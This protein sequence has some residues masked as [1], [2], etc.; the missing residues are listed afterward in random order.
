M[1][2]DSRQR[3]MAIIVASPLTQNIYERIGAEVIAATFNVVVIDCLKWIRNYSSEPEYVCVNA[4]NIYAINNKEDF[5]NVLTSL[6]PSFVLDFIGRCEY[7][8]QIQDIC[9][10]INA[11]YITHLLAPFPNPITKNKILQSLIKDTRVTISKVFYYIVRKF[12]HDRLLPPDVALLAGIESY[13]DWVGSAK[14]II[15]TATPAY[16]DLK[17]VQFLDKT[18]IDVPEDEYILFIDDCLALSF[19]FLLGDYK[20]I[21]SKEKYFPM[22]NSFFSKVEG[23]YKKPVVIAAHPN[24]KEYINYNNYFE[25]RKLYFDATAKLSLNCSFVLTHYS[26]AIAYPVL[27]RKPIMLMNFGELEVQSQGRSLNFMHE[28][29]SCEKVNIDDDLDLNKLKKI[30]NSIVN[31]IEYETY[32]K[33]YIT[34]IDSKYN[35]SFGELTEYLFKLN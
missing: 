26:S 31:K 12:S 29:L 19:D 28:L 8:R 35:N 21:I 1:T 14:K 5:D 23:I 17:K 20:P 13:N 25:G 4:K 33:K 6:K 22:L 27:L 16:Y 18:E 10:G 32:E 3:V 9:K 11:L 7:T 15:Y 2:K 34:N 30:E 24:G